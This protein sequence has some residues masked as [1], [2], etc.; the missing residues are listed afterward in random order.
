MPGFDPLT[1]RKSELGGRQ[2]AH[3]PRSNPVPNSHL[4]PSTYLTAGT[5]VPSPTVEPTCRVPVWSR[6]MG[7]ALVL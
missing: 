4:R 2:E 7:A 6:D 3:I 5:V 1:P